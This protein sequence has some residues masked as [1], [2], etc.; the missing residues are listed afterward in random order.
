MGYCREQSWPSAGA[1]LAAKGLE[2]TREQHKK[3]V[4]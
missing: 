4:W 1:V 3:V 2:R